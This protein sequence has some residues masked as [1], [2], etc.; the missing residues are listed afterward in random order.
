MNLNRVKLERRDIFLSA[1]LLS[2]INLFIEN[3]NLNKMVLLA[4][5]L[6]QVFRAQKL[7]N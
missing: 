2:S 4:S 5:S 7:E 3:F 6:H 1:L